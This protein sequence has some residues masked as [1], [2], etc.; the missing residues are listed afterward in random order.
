M[1]ILRVLMQVSS[2]GPLVTGVHDLALVLDVAGIHALAGVSSVV[3]PTITGLHALSGT[4]A[5]AS[6]SEVVGSS[7]AGVVA[8]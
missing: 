3:S 5:L 4:N 8:L 7:V 1:S 2:V 6:V